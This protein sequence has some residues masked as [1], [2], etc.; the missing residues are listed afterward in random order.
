MDLVQTLIL[1]FVE[2]VTEFL[3]VSSTGHLV[4]VSQ[5]LNIEQ[6]EF[7]KSFEIIIQLGAILSVVFLYFKTL[8]NTKIWPQILVAFLP[9]V[10]IGF[11]FYKFIKDILI[12][13]SFITVAALFVGGLAFI[14]IELWNKNKGLPAGRQGQA[15]ID[16]E[17]ISL[18]NAFIIGLFQSVS[19]IPGVSRAG[20]TI[21]GALLLGTNRKTAAEFSFILA[22][23]TML[24]AT[25][26]DITQTKLAFS[27]SELAMLFVGFF[28]SFVFAA[29]SIKLLIKYLQNHSFISFG[30]YRILISSIYFLIFIR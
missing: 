17:K 22:V 7:V 3:P 28:A 19:V 25:V 26:L 16:L 4:L 30:I 14:T 23:P 18:K 2:G 6:T 5:V 13:N 21:L 9:S 8:I 10:I 29:I 12:G 24:G 20:A 1:S 27:S 15:N 11:V